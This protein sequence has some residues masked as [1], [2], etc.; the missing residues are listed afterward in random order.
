MRRMNEPA[1]CPYELTAPEAR[2]LLRVSE[3]GAISDVMYARL[4][5]LGLIRKRFAGWVVTDAGKNCLAAE[6]MFR[7]TKP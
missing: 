4:S 6:P 2:N 5:E 7:R 3:G 1:P